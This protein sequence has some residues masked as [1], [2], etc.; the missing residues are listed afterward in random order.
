MGSKI[1]GLGT[2]NKFF[3]DINLKELLQNT[4]ALILGGSAGSMNC[5]DVVY[6]PPELEKE[7]VDE[8][9]NRF[10]KGIGL[11]NINILPHFNIFKEITICG[12]RYVEEII[13]PDSSIIDIIGLNDGSYIVVKDGKSTIYGESYLIKNKQITQINSN[14]N[15]KVL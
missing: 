6:C 3:N 13:V 5:A 7:V 11:T 10:L 2:Q 1:Q 12:K 9:F 8:K 15:L 14:E 4:N